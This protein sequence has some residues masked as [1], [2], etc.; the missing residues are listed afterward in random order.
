MKAVK[1]PDSKKVNLS[2]EQVSALLAHLGF[3]NPAGKF[4]F[5]GMEEHGDG[6]QADLVTRADHWAEIDDLHRAHAIPPFNDGGWDSH[7]YLIPT[8]SRMIRLILCLKG[9]ANW[10]DREAVRAYQG[11]HFGRLEGESFIT[12][13]LPLPAP[14]LSTW[15]HTWR[16]DS[17]EACA[18]EILPARLERLRD[19]YVRS[20]PE[21][22]HCYGKT[23]W[24]RFQALFAGVGFEP[25][26]DGTVLVGRNAASKIVL[27]PFLSQRSG[28]SY[29]LVQQI[30]QVLV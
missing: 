26:L 5:I 9:E 7:T 23:Y 4:W 28:F 27:T 14:N 2:E 10:D 6:V 21:Y 30:A 18:E 22:V 25:A 3:G 16:W 13:L 1:D 17:R 29:G 11:A 12:E 19:L 8:W 15:P 24:G 20:Q